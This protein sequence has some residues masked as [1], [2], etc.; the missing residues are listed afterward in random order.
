MLQVRLVALLALLR[1]WR[2]GSGDP[3]RLSVGLAGQPQQACLVAAVQDRCMA[4]A[5]QGVLA[6]A[7]EELLALAAAAG[8][9]QAEILLAVAAAAVAA[10]SL[11]GRRLMSPGQ[12]AEA[13]QGRDNQTV[14]PQSERVAARGL[15]LPVGKGASLAG[16]R[17]LSR[18]K[19]GQA[20]EIFWTP[21]TKPWWGLAVGVA[22]PTTSSALAGT[23][24]QEEAAA[25]AGTTA[26]L[27]RQ[28]GMAGLVVGVAASISALAAQ[29]VLV[30]AAEELLAL[31][32]LAVLV[33][34]AEAA[35]Q[36]LPRQGPAVADSSSMHGLRGTDHG[37]RSPH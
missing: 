24:A 8:E 32:L 5:A 21:S 27:G 18:L 37:L 11:A 17:F 26:A 25:G 34:P 15:L 28:E 20:P 9:G 31:D 33:A 3:A 35:E 2:A 10:C 4:L 16:L 12:A 1:L 22:T 13:P 29:G 7:A 19:T 6:L 30:V 23:A 36:A 14:E